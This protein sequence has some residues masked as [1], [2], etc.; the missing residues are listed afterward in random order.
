MKTLTNPPVDRKDIRKLI[1]EKLKDQGMTTINLATAIDF[2][3]SNLV[4]YLRYRRGIPHDV[5]ERI[6]AYLNI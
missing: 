2:D 1:N 4:A 3:Y 6:F 5:L